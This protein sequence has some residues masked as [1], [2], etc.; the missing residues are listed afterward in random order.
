MMGR[1]RTL[2]EAIEKEIS[3]I[4]PIPYLRWDYKFWE[5]IA[6]VSYDSE[7]NEMKSH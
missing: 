4:I 5:I 7:E 6:I 1:H 3:Y 2:A